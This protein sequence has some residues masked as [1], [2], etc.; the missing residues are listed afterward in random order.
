MKVS[1]DTRTLEPGDYFIP[2]KG[3]NFDGRDFINEAISKGAHLLDVDLFSYAKKYRRKL[4]C[5]IIGIVG[6]AGKTTVKDMLFSVLRQ[7]YNVVKTK[8]NQNNEIGVALTLLAADADTEF[9]L[10]EMGMRN[11]KDLTYLANLVQPDYIVFTGVG[12][13]HIGL[14]KTFKDLAKAKA[15]IFRKPLKWQLNQRYCFFNCNGAFNEFIQSKAT[16]SGYKLI[17][18]TGED[19]VSENINLIYS[20]GSFFNLSNDVIES[21]LKLFKSSSH[22]MKIHYMSKATLLDDTY[23]SNPEGVIYSLQFIRRFSGRKICVFGDMLEL[24]DRSQDEHQKILNYVQDEGIDVVFLF[25]DLMKKVS[26]SLDFV[27]HF[28][29]IELLTL[30]LKNELKKGDV[31]LIKGSRSM[32][33]ERIVTYL[34]DGRN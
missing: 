15:E 34:K 8:E 7:T 12:K 20:V 29:D 28:N 4:S 18:S 24:G 31:V 10:V 6:S 16:K 25:G 26:H 23:N 14:H 11:K 5:K 13:S 17:S 33:M 22:R 3:K 32:K 9:L 19:K 27:Y 21:G 2:V 1:I 30:Q